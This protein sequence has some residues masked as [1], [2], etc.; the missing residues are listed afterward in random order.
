MS[1]CPCE[2]V[3]SDR[4]ARVVGFQGG[5]DLRRG[6]R[7]VARLQQLGSVQE[8]RRQF[9][10]LTASAGAMAEPILQAA[11]LKGLWGGYSIQAALKVLEPTGLGHMMDLAD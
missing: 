4:L 5:K 7:E 9:E 6:E 2:R 3:R 1:W 8:Y 11:F 10:A